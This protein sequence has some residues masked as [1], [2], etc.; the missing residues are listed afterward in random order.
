MNINEMVM[1]SLMEA[2][3][4]PKGERGK[5]AVARLGRTKKS[6]KFDEIAQKAGAKYGS[7]EAGKKVAAA[8]YWKKAGARR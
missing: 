7:A 2:W 4:K 5:V 6:G 3:T 1:I 8:I